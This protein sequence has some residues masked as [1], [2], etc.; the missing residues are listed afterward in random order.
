MHLWPSMRI[1]DSFKIGYLK[2]LE[3]NTQRMNSQK[4]QQETSTSNQEKLLGDEEINTEVSSSC[5]STKAAL[6]F[7][8][9]FMVLTCCYCCFCCGACVDQDDD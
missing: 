5:C 2:K 1:R 4:K 3:W 6:I 9:I 8:E 7:R